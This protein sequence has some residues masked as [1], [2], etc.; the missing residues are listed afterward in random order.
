MVAPRISLNLLIDN[1]RK[2]VLFAEAG[3]SK[4][5]VLKPKVVMYGGTDSILLPK[6]E[7]YTLKKKFY[8][9][10][11]SS[12]SIRDYRLSSTH[13][14]YCYACKS[15]SMDDEVTFEELL[16]GNKSSGNLNLLKEGVT[17][18]V[19]D[20]LEMEPIS[21]DNF[22]TL[23]NEY[24]ITDVG[25]LEKKVVVLGKDERVKLLKAAL[26]SKTVL[27]DVFLSRPTEIEESIETGIGTFGT[28]DEMLTVKGEAE[29]DGDKE[30]QGH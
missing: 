29:D 19:T 18:M 16:S 23:L 17:Y 7:S 6:V 24:D 22:I 28:S 14:G 10:R 30:E 13:G 5:L 3:H 21:A 25:A 12:C 20:D 2:R 4:D 9:C 15:S 11:N 27:T 26:Q 1:K 8:K